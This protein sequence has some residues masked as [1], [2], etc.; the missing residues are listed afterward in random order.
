LLNPKVLYRVLVILSL[1]VFAVSGLSCTRSEVAEEEHG[2]PQMSLFFSGV[3]LPGEAE[4]VVPADRL[5]AFP[6]EAW[7]LKG[8][9]EQVVE[10]YQDNKMI[11]QAGW[12]LERGGS[13]TDSATGE[14]V[15]YRLWRRGCCLNKVG[16]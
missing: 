14:T 10:F 12:S 1:L 4:L 16:G 8:S 7:V 15:F 2:Q 5:D 11:R 13:G 9:Q 6:A 3:A